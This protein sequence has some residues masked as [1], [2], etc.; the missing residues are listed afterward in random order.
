MSSQPINGVAPFL[1]TTVYLPDDEKQRIITNN[2]LLNQITKAIN[3]REIASYELSELVN[4]QAYFSANPNVKRAVYRT[5]Y[6]VGAIVAGATSNIPHGITN[7][8]QFTRIYGTVI[9]ATPDFRPLPRVSATLV[10]DQISL[11]VDTVNIVIV[12]GA[13]APNI[14]SGLV[15]LEY[16]KD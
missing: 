2:L 12:N 7:L 11:D 6:E 10:T 3:V 5:V 16:L 1:P 15:V 14:N 4:G 13:T 8:A 9:T